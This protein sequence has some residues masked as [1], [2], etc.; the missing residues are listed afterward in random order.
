MMPS[1]LASEKPGKDFL[2]YLCTVSCFAQLQVEAYEFCIREIYLSPNSFSWLGER[3][4]KNA[5]WK[6]NKPEGKKLYTVWDMC[7]YSYY[8]QNCE[9]IQL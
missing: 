6:S 7:F 8:R 1:V 4:K 5:Q 2:S 3:K 9:A